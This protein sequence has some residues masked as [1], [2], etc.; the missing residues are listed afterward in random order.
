MS[1]LRFRM[2]YSKNTGKFSIRRS[3]DRSV[4][5][6]VPRPH[7]VPRVGTTHSVAPNVYI[8][9]TRKDYLDAQAKTHPVLNVAVTRFP[10]VRLFVKHFKEVFL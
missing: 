1:T 4:V 10:V 6:W 8:L 7:R 3:T 5:C 2:H 9:A